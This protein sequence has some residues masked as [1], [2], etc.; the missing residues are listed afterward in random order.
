MSLYR[1]DAE[2][3]WV[4]RADGSYC[5][6][7]TK[8]AGWSS[9]ADAAKEERLAILATPDRLDA[10]E[11]L[12]D[13]LAGVMRYRADPDGSRVTRADHDDGVAFYSAHYKR[14]MALSGT[15]EREV[16]VI[17]G[18]EGGTYELAAALSIEMNR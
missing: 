5:A 1:W 11:G 10:A 3:R 2:R 14:W 18:F 9:S 7:W 8:G 16:A 13:R 15:S 17:E 12:V 6:R 4:V